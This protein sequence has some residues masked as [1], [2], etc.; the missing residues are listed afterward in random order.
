MSVYLSTSGWVVLSKKKELP[1]HT[2]LAAQRF[3]T[4]KDINARRFGFPEDFDPVVAVGVLQ[5][6]TFLLKNQV[7]EMEVDVIDQQAILF[8]EKLSTGAATEASQRWEALKESQRAQ[9]VLTYMKH[10][11]E[12]PVVAE[13]VCENINSRMSQLRHPRWQVTAIPYGSES[14]DLNLLTTGFLSWSK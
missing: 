12:Y 7:F 2:R 9:L 10:F 11:Q 8:K 5:A 14:D 6:L 4:D 3:V 1:I 13:V